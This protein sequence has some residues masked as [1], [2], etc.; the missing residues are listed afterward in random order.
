MPAPAPGRRVD[1]R[2]RLGTSGETAVGAWYEARGYRVL[3]RNWRC[4]E[5]E[6]DLVVGCPGLVVFCEVKTRRADTFGTPAEAVTRSKQL[7]LRLLAARWLAAHPGSGGD[8]RF[9]V[10]A[11][12]PG[13][14]GVL[15]VEVIEAAF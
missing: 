11:V 8:A 1:P 12:M 5:G 13:R 3:D 2:R 10:A 15:A 6:L 14:A 9:D 4:R 7:R